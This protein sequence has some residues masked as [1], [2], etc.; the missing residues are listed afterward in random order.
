[1]LRIK[2]HIKLED[3]RW[4]WFALIGRAKERT[5]HLRPGTYAG[6]WCRIRNIKEGRNG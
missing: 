5:A 6:R 1:M 2:P 4:V 3:G